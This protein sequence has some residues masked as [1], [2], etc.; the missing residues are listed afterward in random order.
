M[1]NILLEI[2]Y[3]SSDELRSN[4][5][6]EIVQAKE[7]LENA[8]RLSSDALQQAN[9]VYEESLSLIANINALSIPEIDLVKLRLDAA[10]ALQEVSI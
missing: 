10:S 3:F 8:I 7:A 5:R 2:F 9:Q 1:L 4:I 6:S